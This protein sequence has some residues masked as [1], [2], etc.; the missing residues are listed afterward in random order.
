MFPAT[1]TFRCSRPQ[2]SISNNI[3]FRHAPIV[4]DVQGDIIGLLDSNGALVVEYKYD[5]WGKLLSTTGTLADTLGKRNP[6]RYRGYV[7]D[8]ETG[9]YYL[10]S[11]YYNPEWERFVN[12]DTAIIADIFL[13]HSFSYCSNNPITRYD[14]SGYAWYDF[15]VDGWNWIGD[16]IKRQAE[17]RVQADISFT[18]TVRDGL[19]SAGNWIASKASSAW[20]WVR[21]T[22]S[23]AWNGTVQLAKKAGNWVANAAKSTWQWMKKTASDAGKLIKKVVTNKYVQGAA[24]TIGGLASV[25]GGVISLIS[26]EPVVSKAAGAKAVVGGISAIIGGLASIVAGLGDLLS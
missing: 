15:I 13:C 19:E 6:F 7:Y 22:A 11:R 16:E 10:R 21:Q 2:L 20:G 1:M 17:I 12:A 18:Y 4:I 8:E 3:S 14:D 9:L 5:A 25:V 24:L 26:P 23:K